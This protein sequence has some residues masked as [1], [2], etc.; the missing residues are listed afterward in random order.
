MT[1]QFGYNRDSWEGQVYQMYESYETLRIKEK[2]GIVSAVQELEYRKAHKKILSLRG[3]AGTAMTMVITEKME[4]RL[5]SIGNLYE[6]LHKSKKVKEVILLDAF[7]SATIEGARTTVENVKKSF[8]QPK[9]KD[10]KMVINTVRGMQYAYEHQLTMENIRT[11]WEMV[12]QEV[13]DNQKQD[14]S[15]FRSG[16]VYVGSRTDII[17]EPAQPTQIKSMMEDMFAFEMNAVDSIWLS[18]SILHF[19]FVYIH[20]FCDGNGR[21]ARILTQSYLFHHGMDKVQYLP[22]SRTINM[23]LN[24][25]YATLRE[26]EIIY[27]NGE[28]WIDITPFIDYMLSMFE[29]CMIASLKENEVLTENQKRLISKMQ[30]RGKGTE[31]TIMT[32]AKILEVSEDTA[33]RILNALYGMGYLEKKRQGRK[34]IYSLKYSLK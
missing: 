28:R 32:A 17:H 12:V 11:L 25:Y 8:D 9:T 22:I 16:M 20:P 31:I 23:H 19:Y 24:G 13:C 18:A 6:R 1:L 26:S 15:L 33:R 2:A 5:L 29:E 21:T 27:A 3:I 7:H 30:K 4:E 34:N 14:G 10:D